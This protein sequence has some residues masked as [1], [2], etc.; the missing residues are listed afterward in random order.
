MSSPTV[1][2]S[3]EAAALPP[4][5]KLM[6]EHAPA[7]TKRNP[8]RVKVAFYARHERAELS[9]VVLPTVAEAE[10]EAERME[11][12]RQAREEEAAQAAHL[13][14]V[15]HLYDAEADELVRSTPERRQRAMDLM[16]EVRDGILKTARAVA[17]VRDERL[18]LEAGFETWTEFCENVLG[19]SRQQANNMCRI[20]RAFPAP[21]QLTEA[22]RKTGFPSDDQL[23]GLG[24]RKLR[25]LS[26]LD[27][28]DRQAL[29]E[30]RTVTTPEGA[31]FDIEEIKGWGAKE[32]EAKV[33]EVLD[34]TKARLSTEVAAREK[35]EAE[36]DAGAS[37]AKVAEQKLA[38]AKTLEHVYGGLASS[39]EGKYGRLDTVVRLADQARA[40]LENA[41]VEH[42]DPE[43]LRAR[44]V[45][46]YHRVLRLGD[47][48]RA[49]LAA[50]LAVTDD[51]RNRPTGDGQP[52]EAPP[53]PR[54]HFG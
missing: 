19:T 29:R 5:W 44:A 23:A 46:V 17:E 4:G 12:D 2:P 36:R 39:V 34:A 42:D 49:T 3:S 11:A 9:T 6:E 13:E 38:E 26:R 7:P 30:G 48:A 25:A 45:E 32:A 40:A 24:M 10:A 20:G 50:V 21:P 47:D 8:D 54:P 43:A 22:E 18:Y 27:D 28:E 35:A 33:R 15:E 53:R 16:I 14:R 31:E 37:A 1:H 51:P 41:A 52:G